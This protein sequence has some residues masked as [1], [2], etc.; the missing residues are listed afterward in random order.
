MCIS[1][2]CHII[3]A[4]RHQIFKTSPKIVVVA[5]VSVVLGGGGGG[6]IMHRRYE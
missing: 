5:A 4:H 6:N 1:P 3:P 2:S